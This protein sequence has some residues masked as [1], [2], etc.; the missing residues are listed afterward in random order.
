[1]KKVEE[2]KRH[3]VSGPTMSPTELLIGVLLMYSF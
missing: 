2:G 1:M 3:F